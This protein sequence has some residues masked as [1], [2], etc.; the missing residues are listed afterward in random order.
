MAYIVP[1]EASVALVQDALR[2]D[3]FAPDLTL[4][5]ALQWQALGK[6]Q[7]AAVF[8]DKFHAI[9]PNSG[10]AHQMREALK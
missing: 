7:L 1:G 6:P 5:L 10:L 9:A 4:A 2:T 8:I 3:P